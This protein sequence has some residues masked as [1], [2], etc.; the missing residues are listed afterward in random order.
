MSALSIPCPDHPPGPDGYH[1]RAEWAAQMAKTHI[2]RQCPKCGLWAIWKPKPAPRPP[3]FVNTCRTPRTQGLI[4]ILFWPRDESDHA[5]TI[6]LTREQ[7]EYLC[8]ALVKALAR[9]ESL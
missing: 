3:A 4:S 8:L 6:D 7:A 9:K 2:Q 5:D 1:E